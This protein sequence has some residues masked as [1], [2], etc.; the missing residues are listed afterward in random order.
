MPR[1]DR[2][3]EPRPEDADQSA[4]RPHRQV[5][6]GNDRA[7][8]VALQCST[9]ITTTSNNRTTGKHRWSK[10]SLYRRTRLLFLLLASHH[11]ATGDV[12]DDARPRP[13]LVLV[14][15]A[16][17]HLYAHKDRVESAAS[18]RL[19]HRRESG[20]RRGIIMSCPVPRVASGRPPLACMLMLN[21]KWM[22]PACRKIGVTR[23][24]R[25]V[26]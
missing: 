2:V 26:W 24:H 25:A 18:S 12:D 8:H 23:R 1:G 9:T 3:R 10:C 7:V 6:S 19:T 16:R 21:A 11:D 13:P 20:A 22:T 5:S 17:T 4:G 15:E 14:T